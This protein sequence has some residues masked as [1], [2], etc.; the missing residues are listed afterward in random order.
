MLAKRIIPCLDVKAGRRGKGACLGGRRGGGDRGQ[1]FVLANSR[2]GGCNGR[3]GRR[4]RDTAAMLAKRLFH[5]S[6]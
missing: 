6:T 1:E 3:P 4:M 5:A 2:L